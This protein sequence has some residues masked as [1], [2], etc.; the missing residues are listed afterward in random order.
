L[1]HYSSLFPSAVRFM[2][3]NESAKMMIF[4]IYDRTVDEQLDD[5]LKLFFTTLTTTMMDPF[6]YLKKHANK[7]EK[8]TAKGD[9]EADFFES[10]GTAK[11]RVAEEAFAQSDLQSVFQRWMSKIPEQASTSSDPAVLE[12]TS[13]QLQEIINGL[14]DYIRCQLAD[15]IGLFAEAFFKVPMLRRLEQE[16]SSMQ[17]DEKDKRIN[18]KKRVHLRSEIIRLQVQGAAMQ[19]CVEIMKKFQNDNDAKKG[20]TRSMKTMPPPSHMYSRGVKRS[21]EN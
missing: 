7:K 5:F 1:D 8:K 19:D 9:L 12:K 6:N 20:T 4:S 2:D 15:Q 3:A 16:M 14:F 10:F 13:L 21:A 18:E 11:N 17:L